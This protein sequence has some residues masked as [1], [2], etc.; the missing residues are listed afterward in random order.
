[1]A[2]RRQTVTRLLVLT[3]LLLGAG[4]AALAQSTATLQGTV[5]DSQNAIL[6]GVTITITNTGTGVERTAVTDAS[7]QYVAASLQPGRYKVLAS[8]QGFSDQTTE[9][10][11]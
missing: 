4:A 8:L 5:A 6:P 7:G 2:K 9:V 1:M 3:A 10:T 11:L